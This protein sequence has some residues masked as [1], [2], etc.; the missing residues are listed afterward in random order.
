MLANRLKHF[1]PE[2][3]TPNQSA[4]V[5]GRLI[6]DNIL[7]AYEITDYLRKKRRGNLGYAAIKLDMSK[8]YDRVEWNFLRRMMR[9]LGFDEAWIELIMNCVTSVSYRIKVNGELSHSFQPERGLRQGDPLSPYLFLLCTE[10][11]SGLLNRAE[12]DGLIS[13]VKICRTAPNI[14][15][16]LFADDSPIL[17]RANREDATQLQHILE[18][19]ERCSGQMINKAKSAIMFSTNTK[20]SDREGVRGVLN[21]T[22]E[23]GNDRYLGLPVHVAKPKSEVFSYL[24]DRVWKRIQG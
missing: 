1:L 6:S 20:N 24:K 9:R 15:H 11:F 21:I 16:L 8:A 5:P 13:G 22:C 2:I 19:Y 4:F 3:I 7:I 14:S 10:G 12:R 23:T 18:V 17:I